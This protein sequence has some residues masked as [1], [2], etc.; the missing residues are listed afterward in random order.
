MKT[1]FKIN[2]GRK[3][4]KLN[5]NKQKSMRIPDHICKNNKHLFVTVNTRSACKLEFS[6]HLQLPFIDQSQL[7][8]VIFAMVSSQLY[9]LLVTEWKHVIGPNEIITFNE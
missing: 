3:I 2:D 9:K 7:D 8:A 1:T 6:D 5:M 4:T